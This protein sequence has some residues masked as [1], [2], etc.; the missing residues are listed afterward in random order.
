MCECRRALR[1]D[2]QLGPRAQPL[3]WLGVARCWERA[4][5]QLLSCFVSSLLRARTRGTKRFIRRRQYPF[6]RLFTFYWQLLARE[7]IAVAGVTRCGSMGIQRD[8]VSFLHLH[9]LAVFSW[10]SSFYWKICFLSTHARQPCYAL[11]V[12]SIQR[13][14]F[15][16]V[17]QCD[18]SGN[19]QIF[20]T[21]FEILVR[22]ALGRADFGHI[23]VHLQASSILSDVEFP[24]TEI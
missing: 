17:D 21:W 5:P 13:V 20:W 11:L 15:G 7:A 12:P 3:A 16:H 18:I 24:A 9:S 6:W 4:Q 10:R 23:T 19:C 1:Q 14:Y 22:S 8:C 2:H